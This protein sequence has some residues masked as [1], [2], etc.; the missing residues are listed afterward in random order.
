MPTTVGF[1]YLA[2][3]LDVFSRRV[4]GWAMASMAAPF[5]LPPNLVIF[6]CNTSI[7]EMLQRQIEFAQYTSIA[8][9]RRCLEAEPSTQAGHAH[10]SSRWP[11]LR[12]ATDMIPA[13]NGI[14]RIDDDLI[15]PI[16]TALDLK[17]LSQAAVDDELS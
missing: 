5:V 7:L 13:G 8:F 14:A 6:P 11:L 1:L 16:Y 3:V 15:G 12:R 2:V 17:R 9:G 4:V 10:F